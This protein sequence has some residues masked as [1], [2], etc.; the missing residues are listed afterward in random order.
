MKKLNFTIVLL[1][2][3]ACATI[4]AQN[5]YL[6]S[7]T[8][9]K[10]FTTIPATDFNGLTWTQ[11]GYDETGWGNSA[12][13]TPFIT[14]NNCYTGTPSL[15]QPSTMWIDPGTNSNGNNPVYFRNQI[16]L[17]TADITAGSITFWADDEMQLWINGTEVTAGMTSNKHTIAL[18]SFQGYLTCGVNEIA[19]EAENVTDPCWWVYFDMNVTSTCPAG[20]SCTTPLILPKV[21]PANPNNLTC[22]QISDNGGT[23]GI[24]T[25]G[26]TVAIP[27]TNP[28]YYLTSSGTPHAD[29]KVFIDASSTGSYAGL[30]VQGDNS[31]VNWPAVG[32]GLYNPALQSIL[33]ASITGDIVNSSTGTETMDL[34]FDTKPSGGQVAEVMRITNTAKVGIGTATPTDKLDVNGTVRVENLPT[35]ANPTGIV[36]YGP[37]PAS[38]QLQSLPLSGNASDVL[39]GDG[40]WGAMAG[41]AGAHNGCSID[42]SNKVVLGQDIPGAGATLLSDREIPMNGHNVDFSGNGQVAIGNTAPESRLHVGPGFITG[43]TAGTQPE[44]SVSALDNYNASDG[45]MFAIVNGGDLAVPSTDPS[46]F[47]N[48]GGSEVFGGREVTTSKHITSF[49]RING[50]KENNIDGDLAGYLSIDVRPSTTTGTYVLTEAAR[51]TSDGQVGIGTSAPTDK[52][53][54]NGTARIENLPTTSNTG[55]VMHNGPGQLHSVPLTGLATD[56]LLGTGAF[57]PCPGGGGAVDFD[58][59]IGTISY[60]GGTSHSSLAAWLLSGSTTTGINNYFGT[61]NDDDIRVCTHNASCNYV[62]TEEKMIVGSDANNGNV[63]I[64]WDGVTGLPVPST[65]DFNKFLVQNGSVS[66]TPLNGGL[67]TL[68]ALAG[69]TVT[70][71]DIGIAAYGNQTTDP[72]SIGLAS[73]SDN[74]S[75]QN[76]VGLIS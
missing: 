15:P 72:I 70:G 6:T 29:S 8:G 25:N 40:T 59:G 37:G 63:E 7:G 35:D 5:V 24:A 9:W 61:F 26:P 22:S 51:V 57:G 2:V 17:S 74:T 42:G 55:I 73:F 65:P 19:I 20:L 53:D 68:S 16:I 39:Q 1:M 41:S 52:L 18:A 71:N 60:N 23:I 47:F 12:D 33:G 31:V 14:A 62:Q 76:N 49:A 30:M 54:V 4:K 58:C 43:L 44:S 48:K 10:T 69:T 56:V 27:T 21:D 64:G 28:T 75:V 11:I 34:V 3:F 32:F 66:S 67:T 45:G 50:K 46:H 38:N 36:I 13:Q